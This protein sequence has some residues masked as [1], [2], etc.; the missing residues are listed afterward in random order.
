MGEQKSVVGRWRTLSIL[1][2][3]DGLPI[4]QLAKESF[5][6]RTALS[7]MLD[8]MEESG[9]V[10]RKPREDDRRTIEVFITRK[11]KQAFAKM[12]PVRR[13]VFRIA[14]TGMDEK[15]L[16]LLMKSVR[17]LVQNLSNGLEASS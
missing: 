15:E 13:D 5:I 8:S 10:M 9:L 16:A 14:A 4:S 2:E 7:R 6:E 3:K 11:G 1:D 12:L 17:R